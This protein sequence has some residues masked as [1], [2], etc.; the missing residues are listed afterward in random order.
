MSN[1][2]SAGGTQRLPRVVGTATALD[3]ILTG[4]RLSAAQA[5]D[6]G[7]VDRASVDVATEANSAEAAPGFDAAMELATQIAGNGPVAVRM[8]KQAVTRGMQGTL[9]VPCGGDFIL[10]IDQ[11]RADGLAVE[12]Q[13]YAKIIPTTDR[14]EGLRAFKEKRAPVY[15][16]E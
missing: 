10:A 14:L 8:A 9:Q 13:C 6:I 16:G 12:Q 7:L 5:L 4:R 15:R 2:R 3:L 11:R 1:N